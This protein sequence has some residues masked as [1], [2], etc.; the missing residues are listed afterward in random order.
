MQSLPIGEQEFV[1][2][3]QRNNI[4]VDKTE[5]IAQ[6]MNAGR[7][8]FLARPRRFGKSLLVTT[9]AEIYRGNREI[10]QGLWIEDQ[11]DWQP[12]PVIVLN[13]NDIDFQE[14]SLSD[15]L[16]QYMDKV[17]AQYQLTLHGTHYKDKFQELI[18]AL[19]ARHI[20][21]GYP[22]NQVVLLVDE[23]DK[24]IT[25][26]LE[27]AQKVKEHVTVLKNFYSVLKADEAKHLQLGFLTGVSKYGKIS[28]F[29]D[30]NNLLD[31][32]LDPRFTTLL[33]YTQDELE[34]YFGDYLDQLSH[35][36]NVGRVE[37]LEQ[38]RIW[39]DGYS[40]DGE[41]RVY[42]PFST[43]IFLTQQRFANHWFST[44]TPSFLI[45]LLRQNQIPAY[46]LDSINTNETFLD[47][48]DISDIN[49]ISL[50]FQTGYLTIKTVSRSLWGEEYALG[51]PNREVAEA[52]QQHLL[53]DYLQTSSN[54]LRTA[55]LTDMERALRGRNVDTFIVYLQS[56]FAGIPYTLFLEEEAYYHSV[57]YLVLRLL[58][59]QI[60]LERLT[61]LGRIDAVLELS[62][63]IYLLEFKMSTATIALQQIRDRGYA[64][65]YQAT[66]KT[67][68]LIGIAFD[69]TKRNITDWQSEVLT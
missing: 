61:N 51:Y 24:P 37:M 16:T 55:F 46:T 44:A 68:I 53:T 23:Y 65:S 48:A 38:I 54:Q 47:N 57:V 9:L 8:L 4:Y 21:Q 3:R 26:L 69:K 33:G 66:G 41:K 5:L 13:F 58:D 49:V 60:T 15:A 56:V 64:E 7:F 27:N 14:Q 6:L 20:E 11:I 1:N 59:F 39:Y 17:A 29:S 63:V 10:F 25:D 18:V 34:R 40:W 32:T 19:N 35:K 12:H 42:V 28:V 31:L 30:L 43:L 67:I 52:F 62:D 2:L 36:Y 50:L 22:P 45:R